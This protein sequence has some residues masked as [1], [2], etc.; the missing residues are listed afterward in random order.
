MKNAFKKLGAYLTIASASAAGTATVMPEKT[1]P[2]DDKGQ[3]VEVRVKFKKEENG[4]SFTDA[5]TYN[6]QDWEQKTTDEIE[7]EKDR[8]FQNWKDLVATQSARTPTK[9]DIQEQIDALNLQIEELN[10]QMKTV[11]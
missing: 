1:A 10:N 9:Q 6:L 3:Q 5:L 11:E 2:F 8:R 7:A 4:K